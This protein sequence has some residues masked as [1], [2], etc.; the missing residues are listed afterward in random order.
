M[1]DNN[2][3][4]LDFTDDMGADGAQDTGNDGTSSPSNDV[5]NQGDNPN[6]ASPAPSVTVTNLD[7]KIGDILPEDMRSDSILSRYKDRTLKEYFQDTIETRKT[8]SNMVKVPPTDADF[9][10]KKEYLYGVMD[11]L[12]L[13]KPP[14]SMGE[15]QFDMSSLPEGQ[16]EDKSMTEFARTAFFDARLTNEQANKIIKAW[17][18]QAGRSVE[19]LVEKRNKAYEE[20]QTT[21]RK[22]WGDN[23][24]ANINATARTASKIFPVPVLDKIKAANLDNDPEFLRAIFEMNKTYMSEH[25]VNPDVAGDLTNTG[26]LTTTEKMRKILSDPNWKTDVSLQKEYQRLAEINA[27]THQKVVR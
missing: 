25:K 16:A 5:S 2:N 22:E 7:Q 20:A 12:G 10:T 18:E 9:D 4:M 26:G 24:S 6:P 3:G 23:Y 21:L 11:K 14:A 1:D 27:K 8:M 15:Y 19:N 17:N 13:E